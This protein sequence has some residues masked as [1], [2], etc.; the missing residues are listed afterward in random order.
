MVHAGRP[1]R[2][3]GGEPRGA[4]NGAE[5]YWAVAE[6]DA[7]AAGVWVGLANLEQGEGGLGARMGASTPSWC[8]ATGTVSCS[9]PTRRSS[10][11]IISATPCS[12]VRGRSRAMPLARRG[13][14][15]LALRRQRATAIARWSAIAYSGADTARDFRASFGD[16]G[17]WLVLPTLTGRRPR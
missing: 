3:R 7:I 11:P 13:R 5:V 16:R 17:E 8:A 1:H 10:P 12:G 15:L 14:R 9:V 2:R 4:A 6:P